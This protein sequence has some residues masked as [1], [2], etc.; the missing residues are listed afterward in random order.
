M[1]KKLALTVVLLGVALL[2]LTG[3]FTKSSRRFIEG[4]AAE[5][6][7]VYP[8]EN[9]EDLFEKFPEG[10]QIIS[11]ESRQE[12]EDSPSIS[13]EITLNGNPNTKEIAGELVKR[14]AMTDSNGHLEEEVL[15]QKEVYYK[16]G[17]LHLV[18]NSDEE[19]FNLKHSKL[20]VQLFTISNDELKKLKVKQ[21]S[22]SPETGSAT[23]TYRLKNKII[24]QYMGLN[25]GNDLDMSV[26]IFYE[27]IHNN[28]FGYSLEFRDKND[29]Y[30][31]Y[32]SEVISEK[33]QGE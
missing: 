25:G 28:D 27:T 6:S 26:N 8:T 19:I 15:F 10:F 3:C 20:L 5:L 11:T 4:K 13:F 30:Y 2:I 18:S 23:I 14:R 33:K 29:Y 16:G 17:N 9:L 1:M 32:Y 31:S 24:N 12:T 22:Y 21:K 7:K